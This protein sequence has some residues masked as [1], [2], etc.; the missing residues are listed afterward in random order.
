ML[1]GILVELVPHSTT[2][3]TNS[4]TV[5]ANCSTHTHMEIVDN[6]LKAGKCR[7]IMLYL[8]LFNSSSSNN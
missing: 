5:S 4:A 1:L 2:A 3:I 6:I 7:D 8:T